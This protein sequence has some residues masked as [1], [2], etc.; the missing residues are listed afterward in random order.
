[1]EKKIID[2][3]TNV[4]NNLKPRDKEQMPKFMASYSLADPDS[5]AVLEKYGIKITKSSQGIVLTQDPKTLTQALDLATKMGFV[6]AYK[7]D[8]KRLCQLV[9]N[10]IKRMA[11][12]D[13]IGE[14]YK[15]ENG[16]FANFLFSERAFNQ[17]M[18][19]IGAQEK[20]I[21]ETPVEDAEVHSDNLD[22]VKDYALRVLEQFAIVEQKDAI[23]GRLEEIK[24]KGLGTKEML[25]EAFKV[26]AGN[27]ELL[28]DTIDE[29]LESNEEVNLGRAA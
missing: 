6:D 2:L 27:S 5:L 20:Q 3:C 24:D 15:L 10:V 8:P 25:M 29:L 1:M 17:H 13:A 16:G 28:S 26:C 7:A 21:I 22:Q 9:T 11:K 14:N 19:T 18:A 23:F 12:C 4:S